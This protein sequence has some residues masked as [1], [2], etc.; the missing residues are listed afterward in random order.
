MIEVSFCNK[1]F[2]LAC[3]IPY[4][5]NSITNNIRTVVTMA[6]WTGAIV[7]AEL[8]FRGTYFLA[9]RLY[10]IL[11][12]II[13]GDESILHSNGKIGSASTAKYRRRTP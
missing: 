12:K 5:T 4:L 9:R 10:T 1:P 6:K 7:L 2:Y 11:L 3:D 8:L 13:F